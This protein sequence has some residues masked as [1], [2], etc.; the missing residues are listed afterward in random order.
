MHCA[1]NVGPG[2]DVA[3]FFGLSGTGKTTLSADSSRTLL[4]DDEQTLPLMGLGG[5]G[6]ISLQKA[7]V[8][9]GLMGSSDAA[10]SMGGALEAG[11]AIRVLRALPA[12]GPGRAIDRLRRGRQ[13]E[14]RGHAGAGLRAHL[15]RAV[16]ATVVLAGGGAIDEEDAR[17]G[18]GARH[19][20][21]RLGVPG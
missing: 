1:A 19:C 9:S 8:I 14:C 4:G 6:V 17:E 21:R 16:A 11:R 2:G 20:P 7:A 18:R 15:G 3:I 12:G 5:T 10:S 13:R